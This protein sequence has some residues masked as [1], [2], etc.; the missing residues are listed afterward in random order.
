MNGFQV[1]QQ[2]LQLVGD[3]QARSDDL[4][5]KSAALEDGPAGGGA[6][7]PRQE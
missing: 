7:Q 2:S 4:Q 3:L 1:E 5:A 6:G